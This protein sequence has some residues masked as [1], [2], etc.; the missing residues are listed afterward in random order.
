MTQLLSS[1]RVSEIVSSINT[2]RKP[3]ASSSGKRSGSKREREGSEIGEVEEEANEA[4]QEEA[5]KDEAEIQVAGP[6]LVSPPLLMVWDLRS[7][8]QQWRVVVVVI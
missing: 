7:F 1:I 4:A 6:K 2:R 5:Q 3:P 8:S